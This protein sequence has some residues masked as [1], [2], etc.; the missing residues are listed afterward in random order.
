MAYVLSSVSGN[1]ISAASAGFAPTNSADVSAIASAYQVVSSTATQLYAGTAYVTSVNDNPLSASRAGQAANASMANSAYYD[2]TGRLI[3]ALPDSATVSAIA[4]SYAESAVSSK[5]DT[6]TFGYDA[7]NKISS[8]DGSALAGG[9]G[10]TYTFD[11]PLKESAGVVSLDFDTD[12]LVATTTTPS[13]VA[14]FETP[15]DGWASYKN[16]LI[17]EDDGRLRDSFSSCT[18]YGSI[19]LHIP[20]NT[21]Y[22]NQFLVQGGVEPYIQLGK[23]EYFNNEREAVRWKTPLTFT[24][25]PITGYYILDE[26]DVTLTFP[27]GDPDYWTVQDF[28]FGSNI[29]LA[30]GIAQTGYD[31]SN[32]LFD[33]VDNTQRVVISVTVATTTAGPLTVKDPLPAHTNAESGKVLAVNASGG[34]EWVTPS[35]GGIDSAACSAIASAYA[36]SAVSS[37]ADSSALSS[38]VPYSSLEYDT[39]SAISGINGSALAGGGIKVSPNGTLWI[40]GESA[41]STDSAFIPGVATETFVQSGGSFQIGTTQPLTVAGANKVT[42]QNGSWFDGTIY[43]SG[44]GT[45]VS[46]VAHAGADWPQTFSA[47]APISIGANG[48]FV[49]TAYSAFNVVTSPDQV[50][51]LAH[52]SAVSGTV[53][54]VSSQSA[55]WG[56]SALA[57]SAGQGISLTLSGNTLVASTDETVLWSDDNGAATFTASEV[58]TNFERI[59]VYVTDNPLSESIQRVEIPMMGGNL[60]APKFSLVSQWDSSWRVIMW[61]VKLTSS[62]MKSFSISSAGF[63]GALANSSWSNGNEPNYFRFYKVVGINRISGA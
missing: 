36:E 7:E 49:V 1:L 58:I 63:A 3:S 31:V 43:V 15:Y 8:I 25:D 48:W 44:N 9:G 55:N 26:Q 50:V 18:P 42:I 51:Q 60:T 20:E 11:N 32:Q 22:T 29:Y 4:S 45:L 56:G 21:F 17:C 52:A 41:E 39:A 54:L 19:T 24:Q 34:T 5:Q 23:N 13:T 30:I 14:N 38:Y 47:E 28:N 57:L 46:S 2:G 53:D 37:K 27:I 12:T 62:D 6:L 16:F 59:A 61:W 10:T 33:L 35:G 40:S